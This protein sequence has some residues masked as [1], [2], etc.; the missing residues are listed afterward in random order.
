[1]SDH[2]ASE[3]GDFGPRSET[4]TLQTV[5]LES[6]VITG[7][8]QQRK[9]RPPNLKQENDAFHEL[10]NCLAKT[11]DQVLDR[12]V[13][14]TREL[15]HADTVGISLE[16]SNEAGQRIFRW[17]AMAGELKHLIGGTTPRNFSPC[18]VCVDTNQ[19]LLMEG[20]DRFYPQFR[21]APLPFKEALLLPWGGDG[22]P[23]G[24]L[25]IVA[26]TDQ[27]KF[28]LE[29]VRLM[30]SLAAFASGAIRLRHS[31]LESERHAAA[32]RM[33]LEMAHHINNPL[34]AAVLMV[35]QLKTSDLGHNSR[36][37]VQVLEGELNR[38]ATLSAELLNPI[39]PQPIPRS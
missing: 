36:E 14:L 24:T 37:L 9:S 23:V 16:G 25:W 34:Q 7:E 33:A 21:D 32:S 4:T 5:K 38:V 13:E 11:P 12:L 19:P 22:G 28:E 30:G 31:L 39:K 8:L 3:S 15:C 26:H 1:M 6:V 2:G 20:L 27:R 29:D 35:F 18:G 17:I 10:A